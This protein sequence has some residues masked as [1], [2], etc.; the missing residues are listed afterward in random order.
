ML[1][2]DGGTPFAWLPPAMTPQLSHPAFLWLLLALPPLLWWSL[3]RRRAALCHPV[4]AQAPK[5][6][7]PQG[8]ARWARRGG[9]ALRLVAL[10]L[11]V[12]AL[13]GPRWP[14][15]G[16]RI[17]TEGIALVMLV[18][19]SGSMATEDFDWAGSPLSRL[20]AVKRVFRLFLAGGAPDL[21]TAD[22]EAVS[23]P[24]R[25]TDLVGLVAFAT[26][27]EDAC[28][29]TLSHSVLLRILDAEQPREAGESTTNISDA[30]ALGLH[31]LQSAGPRRKVLVLLTDG[32]HN[33]VHPRSGWTPVE[34]ARAAA[35]LGVPIYALDA[36]G[37]VAVPEAGPTPADAATAATRAEAV[38]TLQEMAGLTGGRYF[39][40]R[41]TSALL[42]ACHAIDALEP[43][44]IPSFQYRRYREAY[45]WLCLAG[46]AC[47][48]LALALERTIWRRLP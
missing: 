27:P 18:D 3:R 9:A 39:A 20:E 23:L 40:A 41:D 29:L 34:A 8:R 31:R 2:P 4:A 1:L 24:G 17:E 44:P 37:D 26:R 5:P 11:L 48:S 46:L 22:G 16:T 33:V 30:V 19:V 6:G 7:L 21:K 32:E 15:P 47:W 45:P 10:S 14:D 42:E 25:P 13:A 12:L 43:A 38:R 35:S 28:P 36:G